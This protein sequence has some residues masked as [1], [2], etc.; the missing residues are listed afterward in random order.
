MKLNEWKDR[1]NWMNT[2]IDEN[3]WMKR[4][5]KLNEGKNS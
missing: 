1:W 3:E 2:K 4:K 5:M